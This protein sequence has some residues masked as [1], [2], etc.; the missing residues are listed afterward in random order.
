M[1]KSAEQKF[2]PYGCQWIEEDD[3]NAVVEVLRGDYL[4]TGPKVKNLKKIWHGIPVQS[5]LLPCPTVLR[6]FMRHV[7]PP[8]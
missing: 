2:I 4:T 8:E 5:M 1:E 3:I 7:L 6:H